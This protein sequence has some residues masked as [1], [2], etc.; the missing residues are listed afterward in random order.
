M[1]A[2]QTH[3]GRDKKQARGMLLN[4]TKK[5]N[6]KKKKKSPSTD[7]TVRDKTTDKN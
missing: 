6:K 4:E 5:Q 7:M 2:S 1:L 3:N